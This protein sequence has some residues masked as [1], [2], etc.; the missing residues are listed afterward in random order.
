MS[1]ISN[2]L[3]IEIYRR[4][5]RIRLFEETV[6]D[7]KGKAEIPGAAHLCIGHEATQ[8]G[9]CMAAGE[10]SFM[11]GSHRSHGHPIAKG[12]EIRPLMAELMARASG[13]CAGKGG[14]LHLADFSVGSLG[15]SGIVGAS[16]PVAV[17]AGL[18]SKL[19]HS[20]EVT[21]SFF[22]DAA[23]NTGAF[24]EAVNM[25]SIW[26]LPVVFVC[27]NNGYGVSMLTAN[28]MKV[29]D[30]A[31]RAG[32]YG[33]P[34]V[35]VDG[36]D[37]IAVYEAVTEACA[38]ARAGDGPTLVDAKTYRFREHA[39]MLPVSEPYRPE[40]EVNDWI[41]NRDPIKNFP[42]LLIEQG[43]LDESQIEKIVAEERRIVEDAVDFGR[44][45][46]RCEP[47]AAF[48]DLYCE[49]PADRNAISTFAV[50]RPEPQTRREITYLQAINEAQHEELLR[51]ESVIVF[52]EDVRCNLWGGT[53]FAKEFPEER[54]FD[55]PIS[56]EGFVGAAVGAAM[57]GLRP[58]VDMTIASFLYVAMD[59]LVSQAAKSRYMFGGQA[60][61]P[62]TYRATMMYGTSVGAHHSDRPYPMFMNVPGLKIV[63]PASPFDAKGLIKAA[64]RDDNPV[65]V[66]EDIWLWFTPGHV[67]DE[68][69][70]VPLGVA[71]IKR[72]GSDISLVAISSGVPAA[73][74]AAEE[75][76]EQG[77]SAEVIDPRT[78][79]PLD[80]ETILTSVAK[81]GHL[82]VVDPAHGT[83]SAASEISA[84]VA[85]HG[86]GSLRAPIARVTTPDTQ[87]PFAPEMETPLF[88]NKD[89]VVTAAKKV[90]A[91]R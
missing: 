34:G 42:R 81:T 16:I 4:M 2:D 10:G 20:G 65:L 62:V 57:T 61:I 84:I 13:V 17:G 63:T 73:L 1:A 40:E 31:D 5:L 21:L 45:S 51:D 19:R 74:Q 90:L 22:G 8:V 9:A 23:S 25:A 79:V 32:A 59:P 75:L 71:D 77:I 26:N 68:D 44:K 35:V 69:Y 50:D 43:V 52:G 60:T 58:V 27:E 89:R 56:E 11:T 70:I 66:F 64:I 7:L 37:P 87:I 54:V 76:A 39:E 36:Q 6:V 15:E 80:T 72:R 86:F 30:V 3:R 67:P 24:H 53:G 78:L 83:C 55:T 18:S 82:V 46:P 48:D 85:E 49:T 12:A 38:R 88:P 33:L 29:K 47:S 41:E 91:A 14:S 28:V